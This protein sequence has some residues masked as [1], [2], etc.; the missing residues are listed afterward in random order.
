M[1]K[2][3][4][5]EAVIR[6]E[7]RNILKDGALVIVVSYLAVLPKKGANSTLPDTKS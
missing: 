7:E 2:T 1:N 6:F 4:S 3:L 5:G